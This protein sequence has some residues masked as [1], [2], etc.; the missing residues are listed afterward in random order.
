MTIRRAPRPDTGFYILDRKIAED[1][2]MSWA[3]RG[4]LIFLL[5]KPDN[6]EVSVK[7][8]I[9]Q[10]K[11]AV[12][13]SSSRDAVRVILKELETI[14]YLQVDQARQSTGRFEGVAYIVHESPVP[15]KLCEPGP[16]TGNPSPVDDSPETDFPAPVKPAS[17]KPEAENPHLVS[18]DKTTRNQEEHQDSCPPID[19]PV[20]AE[21]YSKLARSIQARIV[22]DVFK[23]WQSAMES[24]RSRLDE[25]RR[26]V[27]HKALGEYGLQDVINAITGCSRSNFH[28]GRNDDGSV[29]PGATKYNDVELIFRNA[30]KTEGFLEIF[31]DPLASSRQAN[32]SNNQAPGFDARIFMQQKT[33]M[34]GGHGKPIDHIDGY[35]ERLD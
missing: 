28:M 34:G 35:A 1:E 13:K 22:E 15:G 33:G 20:T 21:A 9:N 3:A 19:G 5:S 24:P 16:G 31:H 11:N 17:A 26:R 27:L 10:T 32:Y 29:K 12:G 2:R 7:H 25:K 6:W 18:T 23:H 4:M 8:L 14:G 30:A